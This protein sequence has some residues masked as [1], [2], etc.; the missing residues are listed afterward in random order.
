MCSDILKLRPVAQKL[1]IMDRVETTT[2]YAKDMEEDVARPVPTVELSL[3]L[4]PRSRDRRRSCGRPQEP[5]GHEY[6]EGE[7]ENG[8]G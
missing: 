3:E 7:D 4:S 6:A 5:D 2:N 1:G 8:D